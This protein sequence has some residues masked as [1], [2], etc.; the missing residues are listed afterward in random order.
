MRGNRTLMS[1]NLGRNKV[2][3]KGVA[4]LAKALMDQK[5]EWAFQIHQYEQKLQDILPSKQEYSGLL[6]ESFSMYDAF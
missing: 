3:E 1:V 2:T 5:D 6:S 4:I